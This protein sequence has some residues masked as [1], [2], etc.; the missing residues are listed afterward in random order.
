MLLSLALLVGNGLAAV[1]DYHKGRLIINVVKLQPENNLKT[2]F[3]FENT[4]HGELSIRPTLLQAII[5]EQDVYLDGGVG[6]LYFFCVTIWLFFFIRRFV[7]TQEFAYPAVKLYRIII[8][9]IVGYLLLQILMSAFMSNYIESLTSNLYTY[10]EP[11]VSNLNLILFAILLL[12]TVFAF[13]YDQAG[14]L[15]QENDLTI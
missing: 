5:F 4:N 10:D 8:L 15:K 2:N 11:N 13:V 3:G 12:I 1:S 14:K 6:A 7:L 9:I